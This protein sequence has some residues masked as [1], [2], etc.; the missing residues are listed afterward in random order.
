MDDHMSNQQDTISRLSS[1]L[2]VE[3]TRMDTGCRRSDLVMTGNDQEGRLLVESSVPD[4][5]F[6]LDRHCK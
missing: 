2:Q 1:Q 6:L 4:T 3:Q 5:G